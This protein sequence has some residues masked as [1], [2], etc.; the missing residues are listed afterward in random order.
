MDAVIEQWLFEITNICINKSNVP[1]FSISSHG[2]YSATAWRH[3]STWIF[4]CVVVGYPY[5]DMRAKRSE[6]RCIRKSDMTWPINVMII[7]LYLVLCIMGYQRAM[8][9]IG[10]YSLVSKSF[11]S[12]TKT[13]GI[14]TVL[15]EN[16]QKECMKN[17]S[18]Q[19][20]SSGKEKS[21]FFIFFFWFL[22]NY[23]NCCG[24]FY[25]NCDVNFSSHLQ[26]SLYFLTPISI[27]ERTMQHLY[28][29]GPAACT[30]F[31]VTVLPFKADVCVAVK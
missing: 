29:E 9:R 1:I 22:W 14:I 6:T 24:T 16:F 10:P 8:F 20:I 23:P 5:T 18:M 4:Y 2:N 3:Q 7:V 25:K 13:R 15:G 17:I 28:S 26:R 12:T 19:S 21:Y 27:N 11:H 30:H 31:F